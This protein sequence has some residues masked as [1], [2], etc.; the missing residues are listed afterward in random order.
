MDIGILY[1]LRAAVNQ[2]FQIREGGPFSWEI[3]RPASELYDRKRL[4]IYRVNLCF[5]VQP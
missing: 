1:S 2:G 5:I 4:Y 3:N